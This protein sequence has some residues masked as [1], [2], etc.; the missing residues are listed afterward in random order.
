MGRKPKTWFITGCTSGF[1][2]ALAEHCLARG[3]RVA[4][5]ALAIKDVEDIG[6]RFGASAL[7]LQ[8]DVTKPAQVR[9]ALDRAFDSFGQVD[10]LVNNAGYAIETPVEDADDQLVRRMFDVNTFGTIDVIRAALPKLRRQRHGHI[11][12]FSSVGGRVSGPMMALYCASKFAIEGLSLGLA[13]EVASFG[14]KITVIE[15]GAF[16]T[17]FGTSVIRPTPS[18]AYRPQAEQMKAIVAN[19]AGN[20]PAQAARVIAEVADSEAPPLQ[21]IVGED[22]YVMVA[23]FVERQRREM[24]AWHALSASAS[25]PR[26]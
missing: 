24:E 19:L 12:N 17:N 3:D 7:L 23:D 20:D 18:E 6:T 10:V 22:A 14:I 13:A 26:A 5:T 25:K 21:M 8:L 16:A 11:I 9:A 2:R 4:V 15:P 1:G